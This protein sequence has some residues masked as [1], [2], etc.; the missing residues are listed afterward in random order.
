MAGA[1]WP[2]FLPDLTSWHAWHSSHDTLPGRWKNHALWA[3]CNELGVTEWRTVRRWRIELPG[4]VVDRR[5]GDSE[6]VVT[7]D[8]DA[9]LLRARWVLG[10]DGDWWQS[11]Y[12]V[13]SRA[14]FGAARMIV[15]ARTYVVEPPG[16]DSAGGTPASILAAIE[17]PRSPLPELF[18]SF[19]GWSEGLMLFLEEPDTVRELAEILSGKEEGLLREIGAMPG[20]LVLAPDNLDARFITPDMFAESVAPLYARAAQ[21][22]RA[23]GKALAVHLGGPA[24]SLLPALAGCGVDCAQGV[25]GAP[26]GDSTLTEARAACGPGMTLWGGIPQDVLLESSTREEFEKAARA[27]FADAETDPRTVV[28]VADRV[29]VEALPARL[30]YLARLARESGPREA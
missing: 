20:S 1:A 22:L 2:R 27:A 12:P 29:P 7:W 25:C 11:E 3:I 9:G 23:A 6:R 30:E 28:G 24:A 21:A 18:H 15:S 13:K 4:I 14:D 5:R 8:T 17:L 26:Q 19:L 16:D 10:P